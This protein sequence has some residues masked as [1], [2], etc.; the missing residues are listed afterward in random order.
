MASK[1]FVTAKDKRG[2]MLPLPALR[3]TYDVATS[4]N[5]ERPPLLLEPVGRGSTGFLPD[6]AEAALRMSIRKRPSALAALLEG[7]L[8]VSRRHPHVELSVEASG[9]DAPFRKKVGIYRG[10]FDRGSDSIRSWLESFQRVPRTPLDGE[11]FRH[12]RAAGGRA[13]RAQA[14]PPAPGA[15]RIG[16]LRALRELLHGV[17]FALAHAGAVYLVDGPETARR[18]TPA[19][20][21]SPVRWSPDL[22]TLAVLGRSEGG[23]PS[24]WLSREGSSVKA[25]ASVE[26]G[27]ARSRRRSAAGESAGD[28]TGAA[29]SP[30][31]STLAVTTTGGRLLV[32]SE[33]GSATT[34]IVVGRGL[35]LYDPAWSPDGSVVACVAEDSSR[36]RSL[37][38]ISVSDAKKGAR[39]LGIDAPATED[40]SMADPEFSEDGAHVFVRALWG[41]TGDPRMPR[42][43]R[44][45]VEGASARDALPV[46]PPLSRVQL[47]GGISQWR[48]GRLFLAGLLLH[49]AD[50]ASAA[51]D[52]R[53][54]VAAHCA[55]LEPDRLAPDGSREATPEPA[56][57]IRAPRGA[58]LAFGLPDRSVV[59]VR[60]STS[61][62]RVWR[63]GGA[64]EYPKVRIPFPAWICLS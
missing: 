10:S 50:G 11:T 48:D 21:F 18:I 63:L 64:R 44:V 49:R 4:G 52:D 7:L 57:A 42:L 13:L 34:S 37:H 5:P 31:S 9:L 41:R 30:D 40:Q 29:F 53:D 46:G 47:K 45:P 56:D 14:M 54:D 15:E 35:R 17:P 6:S 61:G 2:R 28:P 22:R 43:V 36:A 19:G 3:A 39:L 16:G 12:A 58:R 59:F 38:L 25:A 62:T 32:I 24:V 23:V 8:E 51:P 1:V 20:R 33:D 27:G 26:Q 55:W 60:R